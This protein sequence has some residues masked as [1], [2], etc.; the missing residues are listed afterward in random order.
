[1]SAMQEFKRSWTKWG[2]VG[3]NQNLDTLYL[4]YGCLDN[5]LENIGAASPD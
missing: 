1:M 4:K 2:L 3:L 5:Y